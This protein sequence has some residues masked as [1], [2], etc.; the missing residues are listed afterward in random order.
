MKEFRIP[1][2]DWSANFI[3]ISVTIGA[4][5]SVPRRIEGA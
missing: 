3:L 1:H 5:R 2:A 4:T